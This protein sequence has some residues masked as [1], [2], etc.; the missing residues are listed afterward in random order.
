[1]SDADDQHVR[2]LVVL[3]ASG[4][5]AGRLLLPG[6]GRLLATGRAP[7][8]R[9][10][11]AGVDDW[12]DARWRERVR[13]AFAVPPSI[14]VSDS[15]PVRPPGHAGDVT[16]RRIEAETRYLT[17]D[18]TRPEDLRRVLDACDP[19]LA[20]YFALPPAVTEQ[21]CAA[22]VE[23][24]VPDGTRL[25]LEKPFGTSQESARNLNALLARLVPEDQVHRVDH[26]LGKYTVLNVLGFR[27]ANRLF[28]PVWNAT[29]VERVDVVFDETLGLEN[30]ARYYDGAGALR[31]MVQSHLLQVLA[32]LAMDPPATMSARDVR[33]RRA[34]VLRATRVGDDLRRH[35]R[36]ARYTAGR[37]NGRDLPSYADEPGVDPARGTETLAEVTCFVDSWR[38]KGVPFRLRS[39]KGLGAARK[40]AVVTFKPVP[41]LPTG[42]RG[43]SEPSRVRLGFGPDCLTI[44]LDVNGPGDPMELDR[45]AL[46]THFGAGDLPAYGEVLAGVLE[47]DPL[48][49]VRGDVA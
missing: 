42:L 29:H 1:M 2:T 9:L 38:W 8:L 46:T 13:E 3:G 18:V 32:V 21:A 24:G 7:H 19:P 10:V 36:R 43:R 40:E 35:S 28:E 49:S 39:G 23:T 37:V 41:H 34:E 47:G 48:L 12:D 25:V 16:L 6:L 17:A 31:D 15:E 4:D 45:V 20:L 14:E 33:D 44:E 5:L 27:F 26:F 11:G 22:L 30:R